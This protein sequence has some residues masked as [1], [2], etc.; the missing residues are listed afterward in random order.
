MTPRALGCL[1]LL[2]LAGCTPDYPEEAPGTIPFEPSR[3]LTTEV[4]TA[5]PYSGSN[6]DVLAAQRTYPTGLE[7]HR[8]LVL[9]TCGGSA[10]V[11]HNQKEYPDL[12]TPA[13]F[14]AAIGAPCNVQPGDW[15]TV[16]DRCERQGDRFRLEGGEAGGE[17]EVGWFEY[18]PG[19][20]GDGPLTGS[21]PGL[22]LH[23]SAPANARAGERWGRGLF[24]RTFVSA[25]GQVEQLTFASYETSWFVLGDGR[26]V[27]GRVRDY[28]TDDVERLVK[29]GIVQ[30]DHNRNGTYGARAAEP[31]LELFPGAPERSYLVARLRGH[32]D[33]TPIPGTRMPLANAPPTVPDMVALACFI[34]GLPTQGLNLESSIDYAR[35]GRWVQDPSQLALGPVG[36]SWSQGIW[37]WLRANCAGCHNAT[38]ARGGLDVDSPQAWTRLTTTGPASRPGLKYIQ[39]KDLYNSYLWRKVT[40]DGLE[41]SVDGGRMPQTDSSPYYRVL[42]QAELDALSGWILAG[43]PN[44]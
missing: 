3:P 24:V 8:K 31:A 7:L 41:P 22:H 2:A 28:Q 20:A 40:G 13:T 39:P 17:V 18:V 33:G 34:Q 6:A 21:S 16:F 42:P 43:A 14:V 9:R 30:G 35:C 12:H 25:S 26:H 4:R 36:T 32:M 1:V 5:T 23:L 15:S 29:S 19:D 37:P 27:V 44:D 38:D 10:G 11:C